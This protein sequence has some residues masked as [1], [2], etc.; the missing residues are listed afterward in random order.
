MT[1]WRIYKHPING[2]VKTVKQGW[3]WPAFLFLGWWALFKRLWL[4]GVALLFYSS[5]S[6]AFLNT[7]DQTGEDDLLLL[8]FIVL[9]IGIRVY[10]GLRGNSLKEAKIITRGFDLEG[11]VDAPRSDA[12][13][14]LWM[15]QHT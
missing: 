7:L 2:K 13:L 12:A 11:D 1:Q 8:L 14:V 15:K 10:L 4:L 6:G 9:E 5:I 3:S